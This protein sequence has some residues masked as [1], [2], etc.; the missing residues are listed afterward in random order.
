M[1]ER[2]PT[3]LSSQMRLR[4]QSEEGQGFG[5]RLPVIWIPASG[6]GAPSFSQFLCP[7]SAGDGVAGHNNGED[8]G[9]RPDVQW[10]ACPLW[11]GLE[12][13]PGSL[14]WLCPA[15]PWGGGR[16]KEGGRGR[17]RGGREPDWLSRKSI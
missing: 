17:R 5:V 16:G 9:P 3:T 11:G 2:G 8:A 6:P 7:Y 14:V 15:D 13:N 10:L 12:R 1:L 4:A